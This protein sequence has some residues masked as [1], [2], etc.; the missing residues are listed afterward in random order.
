VVVVS[1]LNSLDNPFVWDDSNAI[2]SNPTIRSIW[3]LWKPLQPPLETPVSTRPLVNLSFALNYSLHGLDVR[4]YHLV[5]LGLHVIT[6][7]LLFVTI[8]RALTT[9]N[10]HARSQTHTSLIAL[11][12]TLGWAVHPMVSEV[13]NYTTQRSDALGGLFLV[14]T[15]YAA[16][17][18]LDSTHRTRWHVIAAIA[19]LCGVMSKEFVA[20]TP[21]IVL[22]YDRVFAFGSFREAF[23]VR[24][25]LYAALVAMWIPL[26]AIL[27]LRPHSTIG[28]GAGVSVWTYALN[29]AEMIGIYLR[30]A[31]WP[32]ALVLDYGLPR[33]LS[34]G[35]VWVSAVV[36]AT[37][38]AAS[39]I[40][41]FR[42]PRVGFLGVVFFIL[43][44]P[45]SSVVPI[46]TEAGAERRM[47]LPLA[48]LT[49]L[50]VAGGAFLID[51]ARPR[52][53]R[54][55]GDVF[56]AAAVAVGFAWVAALGVLTTRR[57]AEFATPLTIWQT[58]VERWPQGRA[59][60]SYAAALADAG[61][62]G[63][64]VDQLQLAVDD[65]PN[66]RM[67][68]AGILADTGRLDEATAEFRRVVELFPANPVP[69]ERLASLLLDRGNAT[70]AA[71]QYRE[72]LRHA[73]D[74]AVWQTS[75]ARALGLSGRFADA[76]AAYRRAL[77]IDPRA[78]AAHTG[79][80]AAM[81]ET[82]HIDEAAMHAEAALALEPGNAPSHN[83]L[84]AARAV[85]GRLDE[86]IAHFTWAIAIDPNYA[87]ARNNLGR[88]ERQRQSQR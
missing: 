27:L 25:H 58:S 64:A 38:V 85:Q 75:L 22:L 18:A 43:L 39:I 11:L 42:W 34:L 49:I 44:A 50:A 8:Q 26:G 71:V 23:T 76:A 88:A 53:A 51:R 63:S 56:P 66:A 45:T 4:G 78:V 52:L 16:Q 17:R 24:R 9:G 79:L 47:Y 60:I 82:G 35:A 80:A 36:I 31:L 19:C 86:A 21:L 1:F 37:L 32:D 87:E 30:Q 5:N 29:Q 74:N 69:R 84:G 20:V 72:L 7:C 81:L 33:P 28:L 67:L 46:T 57:N 12:A 6:A 3:P 70:E 61:D 14:T 15:V 54:R 68:L 55:V 10:S 59:R 62:H 40:A 48:A 2:V 77:T 83:I 13:V 41:L 65:F 73:P